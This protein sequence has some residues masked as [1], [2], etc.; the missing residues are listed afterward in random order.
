V[1]IVLNGPLGIGKSSLA[2]ALMEAMDDCVMLDGDHVVALNPT[3]A[4]ETEYLHSTLRLLVRHHRERGYRH[5]VINHIWRTTDSIDALRRSLGDLDPD[6][7]CF[8]LTLPLKENQRRIRTRQAARVLD[9]QAFEEGTVAEEREALYG[10]A[11]A[12]LGE[13]FDVSAA[14]D[15]LVALMLSRLGLA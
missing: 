12:A 13:E 9:E 5:F 3:P 15:V 8:L 7:H 4:D 10:S 6:I 14:P 2:E 1:I 11:G